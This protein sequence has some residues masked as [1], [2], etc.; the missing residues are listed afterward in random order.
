MH[1]RSFFSLAG[2]DFEHLLM[3]G[4]T[5]QTPMALIDLARSDPITAL[6][7]ERNMHLRN[8]LVGQLNREF[9]EIIGQLNPYRQAVPG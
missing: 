5:N 2:I 7:I 1:R 3:K 6:L 9:E 4:L 8:K